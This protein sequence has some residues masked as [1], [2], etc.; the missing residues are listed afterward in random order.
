MKTRTYWLLLLLISAGIISGCSPRAKYERR[1][2][3]ELASGVRCDS[4]FMGLY[5]G[6]PEKDFYTHCWQLNKKGIIR[7][8]ASNATVRYELMD[9][10]KFAAS[11]EFY[12][13]FN[14]GKI[15]EMPVRFVYSGW[16]PWNK[17]LSP[18]NL[19]LDI[20][21]WY[22]KIYGPGFIEVKHPLRGTAFIKINGNRRITIFK[23]DE[24]HVMAIFTDMLVKN[25]WNSSSAN[26]GNE[27]DTITKERKK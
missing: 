8:G 27:P 22:K 7:Q 16:A 4:L 26:L 20:L 25:D 9:Q 11:M 3:Q 15:F 18:E 6:M 2:K 12:P 17:N 10:L 19:E 1:L 14:D 21:R 5:L 23:Q 13:R 24:S